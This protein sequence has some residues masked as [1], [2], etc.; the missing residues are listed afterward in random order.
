MGSLLAI[1]ALAIQWEF[2]GSNWLGSSPPH[3]CRDAEVLRPE[4]DRLVCLCRQV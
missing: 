3:W 4:P 1:H 2:V